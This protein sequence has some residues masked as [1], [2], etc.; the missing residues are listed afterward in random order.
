MADNAKAI[1]GRYFFDRVDARGAWF[2]LD[3]GEDDFGRYFPFIWGG[4]L[5]VFGG[6]GLSGAEGDQTTLLVSALILLVGLGGVGW[7]LWRLRQ[8]A[9]AAWALLSAEGLSLLDATESVQARHAADAFAELR[10]GQFSDKGADGRG[11]THHTLALVLRS[12][13]RLDLGRYSETLRD[14][15]A[16]QTRSVLPA[17]LPISR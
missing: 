16:E 4:L 1:A 9:P 11:A 14:Q 15:V 13:A 10:L 2:K 12:G 6:M 7:G 5:L 8:P 3:Q 17:G